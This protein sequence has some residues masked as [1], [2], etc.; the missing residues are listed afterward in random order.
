M[1]PMKETMDALKCIKTRRSIRKFLP[2]L[3][4]KE[5]ITEILECG[6]WTPS[7]LN[8]QPWQIFVVTN[9]DL[10]KELSNC[11]DCNDI[12][13]EAPHL[14]VIF[15][16]KNTEYSYEKNLQSIG[17]LFENL[18]LGIHA[19]GLG[20]VWLGQIYN[21]KEDV[22][23]ILKI[24]DSNLEFMGAIAFGKPNEKAE[25]ERRPLNEFVRFI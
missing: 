5:I 10:K 18:L 19:L 2:D 6:R 11:T 14:L 22:H 8:H 7:G 23:K 16:D 9:S 21:Q 12:V 20:G 13:N 24:S 1:K 4:S 17:A 25:S 3:I 15:L